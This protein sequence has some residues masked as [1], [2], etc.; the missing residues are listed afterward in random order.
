MP[1]QLID[2]MNTGDASA[3]QQYRDA[4]ICYKGLEP[5][6]VEQSLITCGTDNSFL[7]KLLL[8]QTRIPEVGDKLSSR[9][10]QKGVIGMVI[11][12]IFILYTS[13]RNNLNI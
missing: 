1:T 4:E 9:H 5:A 12:K 13:Q 2:P 8:R 3:T 6:Y 7:I 10:G 11:L